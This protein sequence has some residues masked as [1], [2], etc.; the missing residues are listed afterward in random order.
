MKIGIKM[1]LTG[2]LA[3]LGGAVAAWAI[4]VFVLHLHWETSLL[5]MEITAVVSAL[6]VTY[7]VRQPQK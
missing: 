6:A 4:C 1:I 2:V 3:A 7:A 5:A